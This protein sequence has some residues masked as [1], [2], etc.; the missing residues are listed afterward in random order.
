MDAIFLCANIMLFPFRM[1][2]VQCG[3]FIYSQNTKQ[4]H[5][6]C[7]WLNLKPWTPTFVLHTYIQYISYT[8]IIDKMDL[9]FVFTTTQWIR[10]NEIKDSKQYLKE[11]FFSIFVCKYNRFE[12]FIVKL[13]TKW[14]F[15]WIT[16]IP[17]QQQRQ[18][19]IY[20]INQ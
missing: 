15:S 12:A 13:I 6:F 7:R 11:C 3:V 4:H 8:Q 5:Q 18:H 16:M 1:N 20:L 9:I 17:I 10:W 19:H 14:N 2:N